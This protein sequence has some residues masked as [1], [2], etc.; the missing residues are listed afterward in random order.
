MWHCVHRCARW[1]PTWHAVGAS[2]MAS[3]SG[4]SPSRRLRAL[5]HV[6]PFY[7]VVAVLLEPSPPPSAPPSALVAARPRAHC[8]RPSINGA[9]ASSSSAPSAPLALC[10]SVARPHSPSSCSRARPCSL[11]LARALAELERRHSATASLVQLYIAVPESSRAHQLLPSLHCSS[12]A[13]PFDSRA[14]H[15]LGWPPWPPRPPS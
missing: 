15:R 4:P 1:P 12:P 6:S 5:E 10:T 8:G 3:C 13:H 11:S 9:A 7:R 14:S 2:R